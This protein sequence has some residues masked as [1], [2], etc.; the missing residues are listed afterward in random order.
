MNPKTKTGTSGVPKKAK[1]R[2]PAMKFILTVTKI[3][4]VFFIA[5]SCALVGIVGGAVVGYIRSTPPVSEEMFK[6]KIQN[7]I[8]YDMKEKKITELTGSENKNREL[9]TYD[10][11]PK[12]L[13]QAYI[14]IEDER[15]EKHKG[16]DFKRT[17][18]AVLSYVTTGG[19]AKYGGSTITQQVIQNITG[20]KKRSIQRKVQEWWRA[21]QLEKKLEKWQIMELYVNLIYMGENYYGVQSASK[22]YFGKDV[23]KL[24]L[25][26]SAALAGITN[27]PGRYGPF[28]K[29]GKENCIERQRIV[30]M[31]MLENG[32]ISRT[33]YDQAMQEELKFAEPKKS[34]EKATSKQSYFVDQVVKDVVKDL[35]TKYG[36][37]KEVAFTWVYNYGLK[38]YTTQDSEV[39]SAMDQVFQDEKKYF[40][41][42][43]NKKGELPQA[44][45]AIVDPD[46]GELRAVYGGRGIKNADSVLNRATQSKRQAGSSFKPIAEYGPALDQRLI[47][48]ATVFDDVPVYMLGAGKGMYPKNF[49]ER[50]NGTYY[51]MGVYRGLTTIRTAI[52]RSINVVAAKTWL[53]LGADTSFKYL[54]KSGINMEEEEKYLSIALGGLRG[55]VNP[56]SMAAAYA[57]FAHKGMYTQPI[58]YTIVKDSEGNVILDKKK[59]EKIKQKSNIV[60]EQSTA[61]IMTE[62]MKDT[63][64]PGGTASYTAFKNGKGQPVA[65]AGKTGT[66]NNDVDRWFLG[67]SPYYVGAV[68]YGYDTPTEVVL[69]G[70]SRNPAAV[71]WNAVM[72]KVHQKIDNPKDF[73]MPAG[74]VKKPVCIYSGK[75]PTD[76]CA[77]DPRNNAVREEYFIKGTE[78]KQTELCDIHV[79]ATVCSDPKSRDLYGRPLLADKNCP[80]VESVFIRRPEPYMP[81]QPSDAYPVDWI[82]E[83]P[84][85]YCPFHSSPGTGT[86]I[87]AEKPGSQTAP[88][89]GNQSENE[90]LP[91]TDTEESEE[92]TNF[93]D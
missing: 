63:C 3:L 88:S 66:T 43:K 60:Y 74:V 18:G 61:F 12:Y 79:S 82:Y 58:T 25:A 57:P 7:S 19:N 47:T 71:I 64:R 59:D 76:L 34:V 1:Q 31:K 78:P 51:K 49:P 40:P 75:T 92:L 93:N 32:F 13:T 27:L 85:E 26:E 36:Y 22:A 45:M 52:F 39:Q 29:N 15:F 30:L 8:V 17:I 72:Q 77:K 91:Q 54:E 69:S 53:K 2:T 42:K 35:M 90:T 55:G 62:M 16:I 28:R 21:I 89:P 23:S 86:S 10:K 48:A 83:V 65:I 73:T 4:L 5:L 80:P 46:T 11:V 56:L 38:I 9:V 6:I 24:S 84:I 67:Y 68:W 33:E 20:D 87:P 50:Y 14:A 41:G 37:S 81:S 70:S 44:A